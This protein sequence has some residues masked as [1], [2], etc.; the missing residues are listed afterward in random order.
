MVKGG[1]EQP[2]DGQARGA[3]R[4]M[5]KAERGIAPAFVPKTP[6]SRI[7]FVLSLGVFIAATLMLVHILRGIDPDR[8]IAAL[9][10]TNPATLTDFVVAFHRARAGAI[11]GTECLAFSD[12]VSRF[13]QRFFP[14]LWERG[15]PLGEA[16]TEVRRAL[17]QKGYPLAFIFSSIGRADLRVK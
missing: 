17:L 16:M 13:S 4:G 12:C 5:L 15:V 9:K 7:G 14:L 2:I 10:A 3:E 11:I 6:L 1:T 8:L